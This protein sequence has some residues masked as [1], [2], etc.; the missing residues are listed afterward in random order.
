MRGGVQGVYGLTC[1]VCRFPI[2]GGRRG[3][4]FPGLLHARL[5]GAQ[6]GADLRRD[7]CILSSRLTDLLENSPHTFLDGSLFRASGGGRLTA[8]SQIVL[9]LELA[10]GKAAGFRQRVVHRLHHL[11]APLLLHLLP[12]SL[13]LIAEWLE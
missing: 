8:L 1:L 9:H 11:P 13:Q 7:Q 10:L 4:R 3:D 12:T 5:G 2:V 6:S